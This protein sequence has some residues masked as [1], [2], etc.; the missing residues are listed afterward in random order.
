MEHLGESATIKNVTQ[1]NSRTTFTNVDLP[2]ACLPL[3]NE[4]YVPLLV[5][6]AGTL[7]NPWKCHEVNIQGNLQT[8]WDIVC[9]DIVSDIQPKQAIFVHVCIIN[10][11]IA[12]ELF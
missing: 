8:M 9:P 4:Q 5:D 11:L 7:L 2:A 3:W 1:G 12:K 10:V 6:W